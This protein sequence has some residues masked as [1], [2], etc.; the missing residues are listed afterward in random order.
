MPDRVSLQWHRR[1]VA[2]RGVAY[3]EAGSGP[4]AVFLH[5]WG[6]SHRAYRG[7]VKRLAGMGLRVLAPALPGFS[8][9]AGLPREECTLA[10]YARWVVAF[11]DELVV[12]E[13]VLLIGHS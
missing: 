12:D 13:P 5:G 1:R 9:T 3:L 8:G 10:G 2:G 6:L 11:L 4:T 7:S